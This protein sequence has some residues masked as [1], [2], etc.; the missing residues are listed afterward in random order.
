MRVARITRHPR[1]DRVRVHLDDEEGPTLELATDLFLRSGLAVGDRL[2]PDRIRELEREDEGYRAREVA[3]RLLAHRPRS[4]AEIRQR[5]ERTGL[6]GDVVE[7]TLVWLDDRR[8]L[9]DAAFA[10][11]FVR[12]RLRLRPRGRLVLVR[13]LR[14][15]GVDE[16]TA[17]AVTAAV[18]AAERVDETA[19]AV[20]A[21]RAWARRSTTTLARA[22]RAPDD[23]RRA[24]RRLRDH[25]ARRGFPPDA[26]RAAMAAVLDGD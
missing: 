2:D 25:L 1:L 10:E 23:R 11:A 20:D 7:R 21:A 6:A 26:V 9:D 18:L 8:Y 19:L 13:E 22:R 15:R 4:R 12:D 24:A 5:L 3:L 14:A 17:E 16:A